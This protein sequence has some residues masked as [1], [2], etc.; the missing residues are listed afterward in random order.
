MTGCTLIENDHL[1]DWSPEKDC[2]WKLTFQQPFNKLC[3]KH[4]QSQFSVE[5]SKLPVSMLLLGTN[6]FCLT[7]CHVMIWINFWTGWQLLS[8][9][10]VVEQRGFQYG[11]LTLKYG[12]KGTQV[13]QYEYCGN[14][15]E[16]NIIQQGYEC[17]TRVEWQK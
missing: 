1:G 13:K 10:S 11:K 8:F 6:Y 7:E 4:L 16:Q 5:N 12:G 2:C 14:N 3:R 9:F 17:I 15:T